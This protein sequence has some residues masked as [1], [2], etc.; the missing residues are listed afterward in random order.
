MISFDLWG[1]IEGGRLLTEMVLFDD[2][3]DGCSWYRVKMIASE[4]KL[5]AVRQLNVITKP[6]GIPKRTW[7]PFLF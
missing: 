3:S 6:G 5:Q 4:K 2:R 1:I 7:L